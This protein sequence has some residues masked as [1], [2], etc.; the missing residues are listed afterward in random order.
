[1]QL[2]C[3]S[4]SSSIQTLCF[5]IAMMYS[6]T[7]AAHQWVSSICQLTCIQ[8][9]YTTDFLVCQLTCMGI[10]CLPAPLCSGHAHIWVFCVC[11]F[12][13]VHCVHTNRFSQ[14]AHQQVSPVC[15]LTWMVILCLSAPEFRMCTHI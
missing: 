4:E 14:Y 12:T 8:Y 1:M 5:I 11:Q 7:E 10:R 13:C 2:L 6:S 3:R 15:H 9:M